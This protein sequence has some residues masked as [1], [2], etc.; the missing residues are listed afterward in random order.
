MTYTPKRGDIVHNMEILIVYVNRKSVHGN[1]TRP[2]PPSR[3]PWTK[4]RRVVTR[5]KGK[6]YSRRGSWPPQSPFTNCFSP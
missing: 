1:G 3:F 5:R 6:A 2:R 4:C